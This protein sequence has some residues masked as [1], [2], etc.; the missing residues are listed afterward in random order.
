[1]TSRRPEDRALASDFT[2]REG[3]LAAVARFVDYSP[4]FAVT[5]GPTGP[6]EIP[7]GLGCDSF[8]QRCCDFVFICLI[9]SKRRGLGRHARCGITRFFR[10]LNGSSLESLRDQPAKV[11]LFSV[12]TS[13]VVEAL[14]AQSDRQGFDKDGVVIKRLAGKNGVCLE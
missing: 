10:A 11:P 9:A 1:M 7:V 8:S 6:Q 2:R 14:A 5:H 13:A 12:N 4:N 3:L